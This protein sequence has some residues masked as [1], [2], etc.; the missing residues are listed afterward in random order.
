MDGGAVGR[1]WDGVSVAGAGDTGAMRGHECGIVPASSPTLAP[2]EARQ[3]GVDRLSQHRLLRRAAR[4][5]L[6]PIVT[7]QYSSTTLSQVSY[8]IQHLFF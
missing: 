8:H 7:F 6:Y 1:S 5:G 3:L 4:L 2:R